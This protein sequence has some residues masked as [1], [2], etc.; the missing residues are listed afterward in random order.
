[1]L[2]ISR[3]CFEVDS[4]K[5]DPYVV[6]SYSESPFFVSRQCD[7]TGDT[8]AL[9]LP[10]AFSIKHTGLN[11]VGGKYN[12]GGFKYLTV[13]MPE[14]DLPTE[15]EYW[16]EGHSP[17]E[18]ESGKKS[19]Y[20]TIG[21]KVLGWNAA[22]N[23]TSKE[24][25]VAI[26]GLFVNCT[27]F[28]SNP[29]GRAYTGYFDSSSSLLNRIWYAGAWT[30]QLSTIDPKE[31]GAIVQFNRFFDH[32]DPPRG[33][34]YS[35][36]TV[37]NGS[38][39]TTDGAKRDR[40]VWP[41]D[42]TIAVPGIA[43]ST[44]DMLAIR[45]ALETIYEHQYG[46]GSIP[47][48]GPPIGTFGQFSDTYHLHHLLGTYMY[49]LYSGDLDWLRFR[50]DKYVTALEVSIAKVDEFNLMHVTSIFDWNRIPQIGRSVE[51]SA[52]LLEVLGNSIKLAEWISKPQGEN[53]EAT[54]ERL[55]K[56][57]AS[58]YCEDGGMFSDNDNLRSCTGPEKMLPQD[59][60]AWVLMSQAVPSLALNVSD[61][62]RDRWT[63][64]G[65]PAVEFPNVMSPFSS[66]FELLGHSAAGNTDAAIELMEL[67]WGYMLDGPGMTNSTLVEG[68][69]TD[70]YVQY[71]A[72]WSAARNS[73][74]HGWSAGPTTVL[75]Q[76]VLGIKLL[77]PLGET[78]QIA[79]QL[80]KWLSYARGGFATKLGKFEVSVS[81][82]R[83]LST[84]RKAEALNV[85]VPEGTSG[86]VRWGGSS[87]ARSSDMPSTFGFY[88]FLDSDTTVETKEDEWQ[89]WNIEEARDL[90]IDDTWVKPPTQE[91]PEGV[92]DWSLM[93]QG[94]D[95]AEQ[96]YMPSDYQGM[97]DEEARSELRRS[98]K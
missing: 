71:P 92:V 13:F 29:N 12:R 90:V 47:Y 26:S 22:K 57:I 75:S 18:R 72:Y 49:V 82:M 5:N 63:K 56:G 32:S 20:H 78:W 69:R 97:M 36:F 46:D 96:K 59:G 50:W 15:G 11:C 16:H 19:W 88:R 8:Q 24:P 89:A 70:G 45:N 39:V 68:F 54:R 4:L 48:A 98:K 81:L 52:I 9:D 93:E 58:L 51:P 3:V 34:W 77:T 31:G 7:A 67:M 80:G 41:G 40:M 33:A 1:M 62:L 37:S 94:Y 91:R 25:A 6:L 86:N 43:V 30:L 55:R 53:W 64:Y 21:Q 87:V 79:P 10:L 35:N 83:S 28:P 66:S 85:T 84:G 38:V 95:M 76:G 61:R 65:A 14:D 73:H 44:Y 23:D 42:M 2:M 17:P 27:A 74:A 60:N